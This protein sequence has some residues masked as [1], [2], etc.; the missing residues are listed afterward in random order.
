MGAVVRDRK[1]L[2][3]LK[4]SIDEKLKS[5]NKDWDYIQEA[6]QIDPSVIN[7]FLN[8]QEVSEE[9]LDKIMRAILSN[10]E[11][12]AQR[13]SYEKFRDKVLGLLD[14]KPEIT[15]RDIESFFQKPQTYFR[16]FIIR[17]INEGTIK[18]KK[19]GRGVVYIKNE[20]QE[21]NLDNFSLKDL[22][23]NLESLSNEELYALQKYIENLLKS[24]LVEK[25]MNIPIEKAI[26]LLEDL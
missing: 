6:T 17:M 16:H 11:K 5:I 22:K 24:R 12:R 3:I 7:R 15:N 21:K 8:L 25:V 18:R 9:N 1:Q 4:K 13:W 10:K 23:E 20:K 14:E 26:N 2:E 19:E